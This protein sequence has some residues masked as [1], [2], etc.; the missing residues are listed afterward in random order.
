MIGHY[1]MPQ[2]FAAGWKV[3][4]TT[5]QPTFARNTLVAHSRVLADGSGNT[6]K[7]GMGQLLGDRLAVAQK[8]TEVTT[9]VV[10]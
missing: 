1:M 7:A 6:Y 9:T 2:L 8:V 5:R 3:M 4:N 10:A